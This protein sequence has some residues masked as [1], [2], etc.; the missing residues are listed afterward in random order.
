VQINLDRIQKEIDN[1][2]IRSSRHNK[3]S[4]TIYNYTQSAHFDDHWNLETITCRGLILSDDNE[5]I[6]L[7]FE[8]FFNWG[9]RGRVGNGY[10][11]TAMEKLDGS[12]GILYRSPDNEYRMATRGSFESE[13]A[14]WATKFLNDNYDL[15]ILSDRL[16]LLFEIIYPDNRVVVDYGEREDLVLLAARDRFTG[17][18]VDFYPFLYSLGEELGFSMPQVYGFNSITEIIEATG[19]INANQEGWVA[20]LSDGSRWKF[21]GDEYR[22]L[23]K[24]IHG[25]SFKKIVSAMK[26]G[27]INEVMESIPE[28]FKDEAEDWRNQ[29]AHTVHNIKQQVILSY[30]AAPKN[31][32]KEFALW[33]QENCPDISSYMFLKFDGRDYVD[34]IYDREF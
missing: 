3:Y 5:V 24:L 20:E 22:E 25:L 16:T 15:G 10:L 34:L 4:Y 12:L 27:T 33:V 32:R 13:Q 29:V 17:K 2:Y 21:K 6:A 26:Y 19:R 1:G 30:D 9:E 7:P 14:V 8:K 23:H 28:E 18:Y 11:K 31:T